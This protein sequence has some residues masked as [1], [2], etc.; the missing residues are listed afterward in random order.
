MKKINSIRQLQNEQERLEIKQAYIESALT[1]NWS[2]LKQNLSIRNLAK[3]TVHSFISPKPSPPK[4]LTSLIKGSLYMGATLLFR[5][6]MKSK[7]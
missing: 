5:K 1:K 6:W 2:R 4:D 7:T 3:E